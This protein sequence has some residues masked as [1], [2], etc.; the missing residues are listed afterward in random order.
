[1][2]RLVQYEA[3]WGL[4]NVSPPCMKLETWLRMAGVPYRLA[5]LE[6]ANAPKGK[7]PYIIEED[8]MRMGDSTLIIEHLS[9][10]YGKDLDAE[11]T[12][13]Q[14]AISLAFRR[15]MK[16]NLYWVI[17]YSRY[18]DESNWVRYRQMIM[19]SSLREVPQDHRLAIAD[20]FRKVILDQLHGHGLGRHTQ[21]EAYRIGIADLTA[22]SDYLRDKPYFM[23]EQLTTV[24]ATLY[25]TLANIIEV[26]IACSVKD[27]GRSRENLV[28]YC[29]RMGERFFP[30]LH[31]S[32]GGKF[33]P[34]SV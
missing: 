3:V 26:P 17:V 33:T 27:F 16:E 8:G 2:I 31:V 9:A 14:R 34:R 5:P 13:E 20:A 19:A 29:K 7:V 18:K 12:P 21:E 23:G 28:R 22:I 1:M 25:A 32:F 30:E 10:K 15:M 24:D 6:L 11:L 4:P